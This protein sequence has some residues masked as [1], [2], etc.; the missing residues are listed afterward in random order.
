MT[1]ET[2]TDL[3]F[4][5]VL[6]LV[7]N[8]HTEA[9]GEYDSIFEPNALI[10]TI[11]REKENSENCF[12]LIVDGV[13]QGMIFGIRTKPLFNDRQMFQEVIWYVNKPFRRYGVKLLKEV[14]K[15]LKSQGV[16]I[17]I[18]AVMENSK[19]EKLKSFYARLGFKPM[20]THFVRTL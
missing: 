19:T 1:V 16:S 14:E 15:I 2:Y 9:L 8:F 20:E 18:M 12:L 17:M 3:H 13:C 7:E 6:R 4:L 10:D 11:K 5:E